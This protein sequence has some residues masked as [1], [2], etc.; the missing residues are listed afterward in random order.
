M[1]SMVFYSVVNISIISICN[2]MTGS[3]FRE[4]IMTEKKT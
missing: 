1:L 3:F 2:R 4:K